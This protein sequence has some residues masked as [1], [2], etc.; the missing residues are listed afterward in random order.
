MDIKREVNKG[1][2]NVK[3]SVDQVKQGTQA[4]LER[5]D[6]EANSDDMTATEKLGSK[7]REGEHRLGAEWD[8]TKKDFRNNT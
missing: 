7:L 8:K 2:D 3:D 4:D 6:R 1:I 5:A